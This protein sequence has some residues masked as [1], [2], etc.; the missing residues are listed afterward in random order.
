MRFD[1]YFVYFWVHRW[2]GNFDVMCRGTFVWLWMSNKLIKKGE[3][4]EE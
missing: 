4:K 2:A 3:R 1:N